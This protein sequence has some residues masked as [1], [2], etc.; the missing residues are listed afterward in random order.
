MK[1][2]SIILIEGLNINGLRHTEEN[3][4]SVIT[5]INNEPISKPI[6]VYPYIEYKE[7]SP[8]LK[9]VCG[10]FTSA[11]LVEHN[12]TKGVMVEI[13]ILNTPMGVNM[14]NMINVCCENIFAHL[15]GTG[16]LDGDDITDYSVSY[17]VLSF[18]PNGETVNPHV[19]VLVP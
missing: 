10:K 3:L 8:N 11:K 15:V 17:G 14:K 12:S 1:I 2:E 18:L 5:A 6:L 19:K 9:S 7:T 4:L 13:D 16:N